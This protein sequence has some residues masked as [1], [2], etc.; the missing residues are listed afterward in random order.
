MQDHPISNPS[1]ILGYYHL[2]RIGD[3]PPLET[4]VATL[5]TK[6]MPFFEDSG[7]TFIN[8]LV[9]FYE[10]SS[11]HRTAINTKVVYTVG[12]GFIVN[13]VDGQP[14]K[15]DNRLEDYLHQVNAYGETL[16]ELFNKWALD[17][18]LTGNFAIETAEEEGRLNLYHRDITQVR[19][20]KPGKEGIKKAY[21]SDFWEKIGQR[22]RYPEKY[23]VTEVPLFCFEEQQ[24]NALLYQRDYRPG[25]RYYGLPDYYT[26]GGM[27]WIN[28]EYKIPTYNIDRIK[29]MFMPAGILTLVGEPPEG[30]T[31]DEYMHGFLH[32]FTGEGNNSKLVTQMVTNDSQSP[33]YT[34][35]NDEPEGIFK[36]LQEL[37]VQ[38]LLRAHRT[39]PA[40]L[41]E[42]SGKL[43][44]STEVRTIFEIFMNTVIVNYQNALL[45]PINQLLAY[46]GFGK[47][48]LSISNVTPIT[49]M[50]DIDIN[51]VVLANEAREQLGLPS[52]DRFNNLTISQIPK[53]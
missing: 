20:G 25:R 32:R 30:M 11:T 19:L 6:W 50:G 23:E 39:H 29:N 17:Y 16:Y 18:I 52:I 27:K 9:A 40:L 42:T 10:R 49:F 38:S 31:P 47:Y 34:P 35:L 5:K 37:A 43:S 45:K 4:N 1:K 14:Y 21:I 33:K 36:D 51:S 48:R 22:N 46:A 2:D 12:D 28:M 44:N 7:N 15:N 41:V 8:Q 24:P 13:R 26:L 3:K 53:Q